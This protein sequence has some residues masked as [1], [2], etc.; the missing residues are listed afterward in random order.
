MGTTLQPCPQHG[1]WPG[2]VEAR[3]LLLSAQLWVFRWGDGSVEGSPRNGS[4][5]KPHLLGRGAGDALLHRPRFRNL[6][7]TL[8][9]LQTS[10]GPAASGLRSWGGGSQRGRG[11]C[12]RTRTTVTDGDSSDGRHGAA[13]KSRDPTITP[14]GSHPTT[15]WLCAFGRLTP[16]LRA[17]VS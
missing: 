2:G 15:R 1:R 4:G 16:P 6:Q 7:A 8:Q 3:E 17:S 9:E 11:P 5:R 13:V 12:E 14:A 10:P